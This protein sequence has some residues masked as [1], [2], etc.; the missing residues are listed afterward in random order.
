M[1]VR[2]TSEYGYFEYCGLRKGYIYDA[3]KTNKRNYVNKKLIRGSYMVKN[4]IGEEHE[5][6]DTECEEVG[7]SE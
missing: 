2:M 1:K 5:V 4:D 7:E 3:T 6:Y